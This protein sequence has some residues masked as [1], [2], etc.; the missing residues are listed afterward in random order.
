MVFKLDIYFESLTIMENIIVAHRELI[1][2]NRDKTA[3]QISKKRVLLGG[4]VLTI[5]EIIELKGIVR[6]TMVDRKMTDSGVIEVAEQ[7]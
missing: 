1:L 7:S 5:M 6:C 3:G 4:Q 2:Q